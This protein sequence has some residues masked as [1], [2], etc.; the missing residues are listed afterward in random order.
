MPLCSECQ[1]YKEE[2]E[3][4]CCEAYP[5]G[6]PFDALYYAGEGYQ[7][8]NGYE[9]KERKTTNRKNRELQSQNTMYQKIK[10]FLE[11]E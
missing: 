8:K 3:L 10:K 9:F 11:K 4:D 6:I 2:S 1:Y 7:C 5:N